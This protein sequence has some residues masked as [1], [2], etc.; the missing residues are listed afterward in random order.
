MRT[1]TEIREIINRLQKHLDESASSL[2]VPSNGYR[3]DD[4]WLL[5][6]VSPEKP[7]LRTYDYVRLLSDIEDKLRA[8]GIEKTMLVPALMD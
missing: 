7:E 4:D 5:V 2:F 8:E 6:V 1:Q 3:E